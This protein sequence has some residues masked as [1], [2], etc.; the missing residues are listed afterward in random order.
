MCVVGYTLVA[1]PLKPQSRNS[2]LASETLALA[3][4]TNAG[5]P[6]GRGSREVTAAHQQDVAIGTFKADKTGLYPSFGRAKCRQPCFALP[7]QSKVLRQL[8]VDEL[9][10]ILAGYSNHSRWVKGVTPWSKVAEGEGVEC[11]APS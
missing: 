11:R 7:E 4:K 9:S 3:R 6:L 1:F 8:A 2:S 10:S 5:Q